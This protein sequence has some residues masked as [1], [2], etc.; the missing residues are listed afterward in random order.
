MANENAEPAADAPTLDELKTLLTDQ[1]ISA[2]ETAARIAAIEGAPPA[3]EAAD[4]TD[5]SDC[6]PP[7]PIGGLKTARGSESVRRAEV[8]L[9]AAF[10]EVGIAEAVASIVADLGSAF[11]LTI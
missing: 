6:A 8:S 7:P 4:P 11:G 10:R 2:R 5:F 3:A 1:L 9:T